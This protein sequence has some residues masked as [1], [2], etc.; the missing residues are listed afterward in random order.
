MQQSDVRKRTPTPPPAT[1]SFPRPLQQ[2]GRQT[3]AITAES[4]RGHRGALSPLLSCVSLRG[5]PGTLSSH[6]FLHP[7]LEYFPLSL[8]CPSEAVRKEGDDKRFEE[9]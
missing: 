2:S 1:S 4:H 7:F 3:L 8:L 5:R 9:T 6:L